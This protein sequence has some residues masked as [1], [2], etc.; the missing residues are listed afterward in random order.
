MMEQQLLCKD[1]V[2]GLI[3][4]VFDKYQCHLK[5]SQISRAIN[6]MTGFNISIAQIAYHASHLPM[7][8][9]TRTGSKRY[10]L[11]K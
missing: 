11:R 3:S 9:I 2:D 1:E 4:K 10:L 8:E 7:D 6:S 5:A